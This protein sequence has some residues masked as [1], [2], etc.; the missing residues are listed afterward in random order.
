MEP[1]TRE[2]R[3]T[4]QGGKELQ[5]HVAERSSPAR[6][7]RGE[8]GLAQRAGKSGAGSRAG[9]PEATEIGDYPES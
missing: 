1:C 4:L 8:H 6:L 5:R 7:A 9:L 3:T 2:W